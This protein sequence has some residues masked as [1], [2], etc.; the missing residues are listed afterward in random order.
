MIGTQKSFTD[1]DD[2]NWFYPIVMTLPQ[3]LT[4]NIILHPIK[5]FSISWSACL[6]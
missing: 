5:V 3:R 4:L 2:D 6:L 1:D